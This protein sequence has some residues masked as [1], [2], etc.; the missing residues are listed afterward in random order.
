MSLEFP[1]GFL[2]G[3]S[4]TAFQ[5][6]MGASPDSLDPNSD[7]YVWLH[8]KQN[9][10]RGVVSGDAPE[11]G[12]GYYDLFRV[13]HS[14]ARWLGLNAWRMNVEWSRIFPKSTREVKVYAD[15]EEGSIKSVEVSEGVLEQL[16]RLANRS[17]IERYREIFE[18]LKCRGLK[19]IL[20][21]YHWPLP[22]WVH[23]PIKVRERQVRR[24]R[25]AG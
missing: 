7:W 3:I 6:E 4:M 15:A 20:N 17:A 22:L 2:W 24:A 23:D 9:I 19:L 18:D 16:D 25:G 8:D 11:N 1:K 5:Y 10:E 14:W 12:P 21:L 13:D